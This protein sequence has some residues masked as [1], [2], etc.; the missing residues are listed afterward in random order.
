MVFVSSFVGQTSITYLGSIIS[1]VHL[2]QSVHSYLFFSSFHTYVPSHSCG[3]LVDTYRTHDGLQPNGL[4]VGEGLGEVLGE[5]DSVAERV[6]EGVSDADAVSVSDGVSVGEG[7]GLHDGVGEGD[8][9]G[10]GLGDGDGDGVGLVV[11]TTNVAVTSGLSLPSASTSVIVT[12]YSPDSG[13]VKVDI[14]T[15]GI[16]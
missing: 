2:I 13:E 4:G 15:G 10:D 16:S 9:D 7:D 6:T 1:S 8:G 12:V 3:L 14:S 5:N 11:G